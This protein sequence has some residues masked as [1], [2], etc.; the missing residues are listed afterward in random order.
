MA[1]V[2]G[3]VEEFEDRVSEELDRDV[4]ATTAERPDLAATVGA[5]R[6]A[7]RLADVE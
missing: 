2:P 1:C 5:Q 7:S 4:D 6:I 3:I